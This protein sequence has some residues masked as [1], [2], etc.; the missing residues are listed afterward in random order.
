MD[1]TP[2]KLKHARFSILTLMLV[3]AI[4][5]LSITVA[6]LYREVGPLRKEVTRLRNEVG[7]LNIDDPTMLHA[8]RI[9]TDSELGWKWRIWVPEGASYRLRGYGGQVPK[10][11]YP[12][13]GGTMYLREPGEHVVRYLIRRDP[14]D[15]RWNGSLHT[16][17]GSVGKDHQPWVEWSSRTFTG[18]GVGSSTR[19]FET[20]QQVE[21]IRHRVSEKANSSAKI[22]DPAAGFMIWLEPN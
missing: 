10:E 22:E 19:S 7:E 3:T 9:D 17:S 18:G 4:V 20:D 21:I 1:E 8:I 11:G 6:T 2:R 16:R 14:R 5:A 12:S 15:G 13:Q